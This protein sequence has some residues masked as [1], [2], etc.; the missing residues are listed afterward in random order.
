LG[1]KCGLISQL[2]SFDSRISV[3]DLTVLQ[4]SFNVDGLPL[5]SSS[6]LSIWPILCVIANI[7]DSKPF[8]VALFCGSQKPVDLDFTLDFI[9]ELKT[10]MQSGLEFNGV[11]MEVEVHSFIC[12]SRAKSLVK[13]TVQH[14]GYFG[15]DRCEQK[16]VYD[17]RMTYPETVSV[18]RTNQ[19]FRDQSNKEHHKGVSPFCEIDIDM[20]KKFPVDYTHQVNLGVVKRLLF[21]WTNGPLKTRQSA[22]QIAVISGNLNEIRQF[23]PNNF[24]RKLRSL[25]HIRRW[26][27]TEFRQFLMYTGVLVPKD[28]LPEELYENFMC[29]HVGCNLLMNPMLVRK[30]A[31]YARELLQYFAQNSAEIYGRKCVTY[32]VHSLL[33]L[34]EVAEDYDCLERCSAYQFDNYL[35]TLKR[36]VRS[37]QNPIAQ[38]ARRLMEISAISKLQPEKNG[39]V[40]RSRLLRQT[41][42]S[43]WLLDV[44]ASSTI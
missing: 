41:T 21:L 4:L 28:V 23:I 27:A 1:L 25:Q 8:P 44:T 18:L 31:D 14:N 36:L 13:A 11:L 15:C 6:P 10:I 3:T 24:A 35:Q 34:T 9:S 22:G 40:M 5:F 33:H 2:Q 38:V 30:H 17:G 12:D 26:K 39:F 16:G 43:D 20:I 19:S 7:K 42:V 29:L 32:N 37:P